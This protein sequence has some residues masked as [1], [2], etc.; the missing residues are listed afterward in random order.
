MV[1]QC[2]RDMTKITYQMNKQPSLVFSIIACMGYFKIN[3]IIVTYIYS[4]EMISDG[5]VCV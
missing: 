3:V 1:Q 5:Y 2:V 4:F